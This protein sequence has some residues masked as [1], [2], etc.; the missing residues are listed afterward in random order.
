MVLW[1]GLGKEEVT[2]VYAKEIV[3]VLRVEHSHNPKSIGMAIE[4]GFTKPRFLFTPFSS[5]DR[6]E[7][8]WRRWGIS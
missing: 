5:T 7:G 2:T 8:K 1:M 3:T 4:Y 6:L